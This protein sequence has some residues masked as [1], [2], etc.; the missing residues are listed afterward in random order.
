MTFWDILKTQ[1]HTQTWQYKFRGGHEET[2]HPFFSSDLM[3]RESV[4][5][6]LDIQI[7]RFLG[8]D[9]EV[10]CILSWLGRITLLSLS[11]SLSSRLLEFLTQSTL[12]YFVFFLPFRYILSF[13]HLLSFP[14]CSI[15]R[16][17]DFVLSDRSR[18]W[19][20]IFDGGWE[21]CSSGDEIGIMLK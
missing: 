11:L 6:Q 7:G 21:T 19:L 15:F 2:F 4:L 3:A 10:A 20:F 1:T 8:S 17:G 13:S 12:S 5:I 14:L 16:G 18:R 9:P